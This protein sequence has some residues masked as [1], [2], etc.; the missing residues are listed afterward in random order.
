MNALTV[1]QSLPL[2]KG[3]E[4]VENMLLE[5]PQADC[6]V[7]HHFGPGVYMR[8]VFIPAGTIALGHHHRFEHMNILLKGR[9]SVLQPD[10][11]LAEYIAP[12]MLTTPPGRKLAYTHEDTV[13]VNVYPESGRDIAEL[14]EKLLDK[15]QTFCAHQEALKP[16]E[17][18]ADRADFEKFL[19]E[20]N[21]TAEYVR[22]VSENLSD[23]IFFPNGTVA[24]TVAPSGI[25]GLGLFATAC[26]SAG[27][28]IAP[29]R[30][31]GL[32][33]PAGRYTNHSPYPNAKPVVMGDAIFLVAVKNICGS[34]G[35]QAGDEITI[36]YR[37]GLALQEGGGV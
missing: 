1:L 29:A 11:T 36:D 3:I 2:E 14:E 34:R 35:G 27:D 10:G 19:Q 31:N 22:G 7:Y 20:F 30:I 28:L 17:Q 18:L 6:P 13:W 23:C 12:M 26:F 25:E 16:L 8:E 4:A 37:A 21:L 32:R 33:T 9:I 5:Q 15:S 24:V